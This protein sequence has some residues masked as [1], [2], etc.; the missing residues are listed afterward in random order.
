MNLKYGLNDQPGI[1]ETLLYGLQWIA[2]FIPVLIIIGKL[3]AGLHYTSPEQQILYLQKV[4]FV[5]AVLLVIQVLWGHRLPLITGPATVLLVGILACQSNS[6]ASVYSAILIGGLLLA[7]LA[8]SGLFNYLQVLFTPRVVVSILMLIAFTLLPTIINL[9]IGRESGVT[10]AANL[11]F[12]TLLTLAIFTANKYL[13]GIWKTTLIVWAILAG[14]LAYWLFFPASLSFNGLTNLKP[15]GNWFTTLGF[16]FYIEPGVLISFLFCFLALSINDLGSIQS[17]GSLLQAAKMN[18]R[19]Q[20]GIGLTGMGNILA[21]AFG[22]IGPVNF[23]LSPG[24]IAAT[25]CASRFT[26]LPAGLGLLVLSFSPMVLGFIGNI[27]QVI[28][29]CILIYLMSSQI[30]AGLLMAY[31]KKAIN[32][33]DEGVIIGL[34][35]IIATIT[36]FLPPDIINTF[37]KNMRPIIGN[38]FVMGVITVIILEHLIFKDKRK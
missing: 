16:N 17:L 33:Y 12:V 14:T 7:F 20:R 26:L 11:I 32:I 6:I 15:L 9:I 8:F 13:Q 2:L 30:A 19:I 3:V 1:T 37:P 28:I 38:G 4:T 22:V 18:K 23:S 31:E 27:P 34:P 21:G 36:A 25:G 24:V 29:G 10:P 5:S 35:L